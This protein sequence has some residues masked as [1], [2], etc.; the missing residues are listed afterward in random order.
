MK[1]INVQFPSGQ[2]SLV[3]V[4]QVPDGTGPFPAVVVCHP[5]PQYGGSMD[6]N[7]INCI[8]EALAAKSF[9]SFKFNFRGVEG[10]QGVFGNGTGEQ[11]DVN[12]AITFLA[13]RA[14]ADH[15]RLG[16]A[17]Y[18]AGS[19]WGLT[20]GCADNRVKALCAVSPPL[21]MF[22]FKCLQD[23]LK[24]KF[25]IS[26]SE[27]ELVPVKPFLKFCQ[28]LPE[29]REFQTIDGANHSWWGYEPVVAEKVS[30]FFARKL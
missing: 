29:P 1:A 18:S 7:V 2:L 13:A 28:S 8:C 3:G 30:D 6:N 17:G 9:I 27:D 22:N 21:S 10:S 5:H 23:C 16:L 26:G 15:A 25:M 24:P 19:A 12:S 20:A 11:D 14:E 4:L